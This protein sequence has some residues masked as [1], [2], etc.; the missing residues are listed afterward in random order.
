MSV[1]VE[2]SHSNSLPRGK[3]CPV[4]GSLVFVAEQVQAPRQG[5]VV[6]DC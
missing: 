4:K 6:I 3:I 2:T 1:S 5:G